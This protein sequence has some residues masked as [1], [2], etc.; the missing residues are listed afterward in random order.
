MEYI[1][2]SQCGKVYNNIASEDVLAY[3]PYTFEIVQIS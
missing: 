2:L 3:Y 1:V